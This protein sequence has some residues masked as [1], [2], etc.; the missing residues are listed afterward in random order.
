LKAR[1]DDQARDQEFMARFQEIRLRVQSHVQEEEHRPSVE[2]AFPEI[3]EAFRRFGIECGA[4]PVEEAAGRIQGRPEPARQQLIAALDECLSQAPS[5]LSRDDPARQWLRATLNTADNDPW[6]LRARKALFD[7][8]W[9][10]LEPLASAADVRQQPPNFLLIVARS[11]PGTMKSSRLELLRK[12]QRNYL[13]D[14]WANVFLA[15]ELLSSGRPAE[16]IRYF[17]AAMALLPENAMLYNNR[18]MALIRAGELEE[19][20]ADYRQALVLAPQ[21]AKLHYNLGE[22][23]ARNGQFEE[24]VTEYRAYFRE[25]AGNAMSHYNVG[26]ALAHAGRHDEAIVELHKAVSLQND[27]PRARLALAQV[28]GIKGSLEDVVSELH[29]AIVYDPEEGEYH[30]WLGNALKNLGRLDEAI[31][32]YRDAIR[33]KTAYPEPHRKVSPDLAITPSQWLSAE[34]HCNLGHVLRQNGEVREALEELRRGHKLGSKNPGWPNPSAKWVEECERLVELDGR[35]PGFLDGKIKPA[36]AAEQIELARL[37][38]LKR[39]NVAAVHFY[40]GAF[41]AQPELAEDLQAPHRYNAA[42]VAALAGCGQGKDADKLDAKERESLRQQALQW[43][44]ANLESMGRL[45]DKEP[46]R[47]SNLAGALK[48]W[49]TDP[50]FFG[51]RGRDAQAKLPEAER[52]AWQRLW[53]DVADMLKRSEETAATEKKSG[54]T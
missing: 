46:K 28:L 33:L 41:A 17:T 47:A 45:L 11:L 39:L 40:E 19:G 20:I 53:G 37:C 13:G 10:T 21:D 52:Q 6:R 43:L 44:R 1:L 16:A 4:T 26:F 14:L 12:I 29:E 32:A 50:D 27:F 51:V 48:Y 42:C 35:L 25:E 34:A 2:A 24:A 23:L 22:A 15:D 9:L 7:R 54:A 3:L 31:L 38:F 18:G 8:D 5:E 36:S 49:L 30:Y